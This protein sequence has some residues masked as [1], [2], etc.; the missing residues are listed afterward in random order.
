MDKSIKDKL[1]NPEIIKGMAEHLLKNFGVFDFEFVHD[2]KT[3]N[4]ECLYTFI[5]F[6]SKNLLIRGYGNFP[7]EFQ[8]FYYKN[9]QI[10]NKKDILESFLYLVHNFRSPFG[11]LSI[12]REDFRVFEIEK[13]RLKIFEKGPWQKYLA[14]V[15]LSTLSEPL[16]NDPSVNILE[17]S[18]S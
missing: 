10:G 8:D 16:I 17:T 15:Y 6:P 4:D 12:L 5:D 2:P 9:P 1:D 7:K 3:S 14:K 13:D 11:T 18:H